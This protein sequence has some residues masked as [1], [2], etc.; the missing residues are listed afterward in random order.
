MNRQNNKRIKRPKVI[1]GEYPIKCFISSVMNDY[2][3]S[4]RD[5]ITLTLGNS[6]FITPWTFEYTPGSSEPLDNGC[7]RH[8]RESDFVFWIV[9]SEISPIVFKEVKEAVL[10]KKRLLVI[11]IDSEETWSLETKTLIKEIGTNSKWIEP[12]KYSSLSEAIKMTMQDEIIRSLRAQGMEEQAYLED[13]NKQS[14]ARCVTRWIAAGVLREDAIKMTKDINIGKPPKEAVPTTEKPLVILINEFGAGK[15]LASERLLQQAISNIVKTPTLPIPV[16]IQAQEIKESLISYILENISGVGNPRTQ[17]VFLVIDGVDEVGTATALKLINEARTLVEHWQNTHILITSRP[18][19]AIENAEEVRHLSTLTEKEAFKL[20]NLIAGREVPISITFKFP[21]SVKEAIKRPLFAILVGRYIRESQDKIPRST[22]ELLSTL[23][24]RSLS[25]SNLKSNKTNPIL[26]KLAIEII[27]RD[28]GYIPINE[29]AESDI[30]EGLVATGLLVSRNNTITF[31]LPILTQWFAAQAFKEELIDSNEIC[32][33]GKID[34]WKYSLII[35]IGIFDHD[36]VTKI[37]EPIVRNDPGIASEIV[38]EGLNR[39]G[40]EED[41]FPPPVKLAGKRIRYSMEAWISGIGNI[42]KLI[43]PTNKEDKLLPIGAKTMG[44]HLTTGWYVGKESLETVEELP[45]SLN[46]FSKQLEWTS[47]RRARPGRQSAWAWRWS[48]DELRSRL[49]NILEKRKLKSNILTFL[50]EDLYY[51]V[52]DL[53]NFGS[54]CSEDIDIQIIKN[55]LSKYPGGST[56]IKNGKYINMQ[57]IRSAIEIYEKNNPDILK[58]PYPGPDK[59]YSTN[60]VWS[61]YSDNQL[62]HR[63]RAIYEAALEIYSGLVNEWFEGLSKRLLVAVTL[64]AILK[65]YLHIPTEQNIHNSPK[66]L[67]YLHALPKKS[68]TKIE[69]TLFSEKISFK[70]LN[71]TSEFNNLRNLRPEA[72]EWIDFISHHSV[73]NIFNRFPARELAYSWL[74]SDLNR[75]YWLE[76]SLH[77]RLF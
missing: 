30:V 47:L 52:A 64:P 62:L 38:E 25:T 26:C 75:I 27:S 10:N 56:L 20:I 3:Q 11:L 35:A 73:L 66:L 44:A 72:F 55:E 65:G 54:S 28:G 2:Y 19:S 22:G 17:G 67:W 9:T 37:F 7:L 8:V 15:S 63:T 60:L 18:I 57:N 31:A 5:E 29:I 16:Y 71:D 32:I 76:H 77:H 23:I 45:E 48:W 68:Q 1:S 4:A 24:D 6:P 53:L 74:G 50:H 42:Y 34:K 14:Y 13:I 49:E 39:W 70:D 12:N 40:L 51:S 69:I 41:V 58:A 21:K 43:A 36:L 61:A 59:K 46:I 33:S